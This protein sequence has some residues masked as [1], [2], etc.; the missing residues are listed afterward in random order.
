MF[1]CFVVSPR[2]P[3]VPSLAVYSFPREH[4]QPFVVGVS[5]CH[6]PL[7]PTGSTLHLSR[8]RPNTI[9]LPRLPEHDQ[10]IINST[11]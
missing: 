8:L 9:R 2:S 7:T 10:N 6:A 11:A 3:C 5:L 1:G 4:R